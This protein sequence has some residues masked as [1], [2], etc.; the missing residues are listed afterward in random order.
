L[1]IRGLNASLPRRVEEFFE[2]NSD[3]L[4][5]KEELYNKEYFK[6][7]DYTVDGKINKCFNKI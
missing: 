3:M 7:D 1:F 6:I 4:L 5:I 2:Y